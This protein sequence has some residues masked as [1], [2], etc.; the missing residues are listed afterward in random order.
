MLKEKVDKLLNSAK[1]KR[2]GARRAIFEVLLKA[3]R[4]RTAD[5]IASAIGKGCPNKVTVY[6]TLESLVGAGLAHKA[7]VDDRSQYYETADRCSESQC[8]PH[9]FCTDCEQTHCLTQVTVP[10]ASSAPAGFIINR[11]QVRLEGICP[12]CRKTVTS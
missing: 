7:Y 11:Q 10:M 1:L 8:H 3:T 6:R 2:T 4:P 9:F 12:S 5:E